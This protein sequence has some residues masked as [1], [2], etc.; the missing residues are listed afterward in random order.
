MTRTFG[1]TGLPLLGGRGA[2]MIFVS[3]GFGKDSRAR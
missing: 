3:R 2:A 1:V